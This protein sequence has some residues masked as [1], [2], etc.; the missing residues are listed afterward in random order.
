MCLKQHLMDSHVEYSPENLRN[1]SEEQGDRFYQ[2]IKVMEQIDY[3]RWDENMIR[4][5]VGF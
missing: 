2:D 4:T 3:G 5:T 1:N